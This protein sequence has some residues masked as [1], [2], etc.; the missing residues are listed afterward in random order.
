MSKAIEKSVYSSFKDS[1]ILITGA[2]GMISRNVIRLIE[3]LNDEYNL[4][5]SV[6]AH[7]L[8]NEQVERFFSD[9]EKP[10]FIR[11]VASDIRELEVDSNVD[12]IIHTAGITGGSKQHID[13]PVTT[14]SVALDGTKR[15]LEIAKDKAVKS[16]VYL[17]SLEVY[18]KPDGSSD[19]I[20]ESASGY[21]DSV[22]VRSSYSE[23]KRMCECMCA[24]YTKQFGVPTVIARL[25]ATFGYGVDYRDNRVFSQ[26]AR[27][28]LEQK[29]IVLKSTGSTVRN[30]C[31]AADT[32]AAL[33]L[34][35]IKGKHGEAYNIA[36]MDTEISIKNLAMK[37]I[38]MYPE[39]GVA[40]KFDLQEDP[41]KLGYN[42][43]M[44]NVLDSGKIMALGWKP[45]YGVDDM[46]RH[47]ITSMKNS[48]TNQGG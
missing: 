11:T 36:N 43:E 14:I 1:T 42:A 24:S 12:Y 34:L 18:G 39:S 40:L 5:I 26:F 30:Y 35:L 38:E 9:S 17:S 28:I 15:V 45:Q 21:I 31:D 6:I 23:S 27:S 22:N 10:S 7:V 16:V 32:A 20:T 29:D 4:N 13:S 47:L 48:I 8:N 3:N 41:S 25:T 37:F 44:R 46:I 33:L 2:A 19:T